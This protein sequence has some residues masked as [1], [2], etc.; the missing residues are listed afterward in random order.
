[1]AQKP[2]PLDGLVY[3]QEGR[4]AFKASVF[5]SVYDEF[6]HIS[7]GRLVMEGQTSIALLNQQAFGSFYQLAVA[8][9]T[10]HRLAIAYDSS[11]DTA[12]GKKDLSSTNI[13]T[14]LSASTSS[15]SEGSSILS[16]TNS[17]DPLTADLS[18]TG[19][20]LQLLGLLKN[21][22]PAGEI[23]HGC[24]MNALAAGAGQWPSVQGY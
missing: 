5:L 14:S 8:L 2:I 11:S 6:S 22:I 4:L 24:P 9:L 10:G 21:I 13:S 19:Y 18:R 3:I 15:L 7:E 20:G 23:V 16:L 17:D 1:M 12:T